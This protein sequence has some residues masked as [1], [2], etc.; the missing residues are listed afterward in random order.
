MAASD[1]IAT[2]REAIE[3]NEWTEAYGLLVHA[4]ATV[5]L[6]A[7]GF[8]DLARCAWWSG[9]PDECIDAREQAY[10]GYI[11]S[12]QP[13]RAAL[14][15]LDLAE[16]HFNKKAVALGRSWVKRAERLL[17][18]EP[19][20]VEHGYLARSQAVIAFE[21]DNDLDR[22]LE[23]A[24]RAS[25]LGA[26][27]ADPDLQAIALHDE[28]RI[29]VALGDVEEGMVLM[30][31]AMV[32][33][34]GGELGALY[35][36]KIYCN[37]IDICEQLADYR[38]AGDWSD[39]ARRWCERA[40]HSSGF[41]GVCRIHRA[42][43]MRLRGDWEAAE[44]EALRASDELGN[45][46][47]FSGEAFYEIG[48]IRLHMGDFERAEE[49][50]R[51]AHGLGRDPQPG[52]AEL[53][54]AQG[55]PTGAWT[56]ISHSLANATA[57]LK[58]A[59]LLPAAI[60][61]ALANDDL[62]SAGEAVKELSSIADEYGSPALLAHADHGRGAVLL[63][64]GNL[65]QAVVHLRR[66]TES[67]RENDLPYLAAKSRMVLAE[68]YRRQ[69]SVD[70][71]E[72]EFDAARVTFQNLGA[73]ADV[74]AAVQALKA[75][76]QD[77]ATGD[78]T[79]AALMFTDIVDSTPLIGVIGDEAW[80]QLLRWH[81]RTLRSLFAGHGGREVDN[82]GDGFF[83]SFHQ[84][85]AAVDCAV[86]IQR[87]LFKQREDHGFAPEVR[88][89]LHVGEVTEMATSLAGGEVHKTARISSHAAGGEILA[90]AELAALVQ[91][92]AGEPRSIEL[93]GFAA[94]A[95]VVSVP[96][97]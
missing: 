86:E 11:K 61:V 67:W 87:T 62:D 34:I 38:R 33:A 45:F 42:E 81:D 64:G 49:A 52:M 6:D 77:T 5:G 18:P 72:M 25:E 29:T 66:A 8:E 44:K 63:A 16:G 73:M 20:S 2:A 75:P 31:E 4:A 89:G 95:D 47:D 85:Q 74:Q 83:V 70:S 1:L 97:S 94:K 19:E 36:G 69:G 57:P 21:A 82:T 14:M 79:T 9:L 80:E 50:F 56:L 12:D 30:D 71:A 7:E 65:A 35:T 17:E 27:F 84:P 39:A 13:K 51:Q 10:A 23:L 41:P 78:R 55:N 88:I 40:G 28:G 3:R 37:M 76:A 68:A 15:A 43:I 54:L 96:W 46:V 92:A 53:R 90:S 93:K 91:D 32:A 60:A 22:G 58:R 26:T 48:E 59:R 24:R